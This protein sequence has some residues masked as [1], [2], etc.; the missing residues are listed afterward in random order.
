MQLLG[1]MVTILRHQ[2][3]MHAHTHTHTHAFEVGMLVSTVT[4]CHYER[5]YMRC[6][7]HP[8]CTRHKIENTS[9]SRH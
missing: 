9:Y 3:R 4:C 2:T 8:N 5:L 6:Y 7:T 1:H